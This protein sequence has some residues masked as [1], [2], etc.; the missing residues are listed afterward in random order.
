MA[1]DGL[2]EAGVHQGAVAPFE[3]RRTGDPGDLRLSISNSLGAFLESG[4]GVFK[5]PD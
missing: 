3:L 5:E 2:G 1:A 4:P